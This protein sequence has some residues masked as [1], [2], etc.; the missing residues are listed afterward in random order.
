MWM[1]TS[2]FY[3]IYTLRFC[4]AGEENTFDPSTWNNAAQPETN[5]LA[6]I[7][8]WIPQIR[9]TGADTVYFTP[10]F[11]SDRHGYD[12][13]DYYTIDSRLGSDEDFAEV[14]RVLHAAGLRVVLDAVFNHVGRGFWAFRDVQIHGRQSKYVDWFVIDWDGDSDFADGF[15]Y[16]GWEGHFDLVKLNLL[17]PEVRRHLFGALEKWV[18]LFH[19]D[20]LRLDVAYCLD[21]SF[22]AELRSRCD[23]LPD[24]RGSNGI[25]L[26][27]ETI[28]GEHY[29]LV[30]DSMLHACTNYELYKSLYSGCN[31]RNMFELSWTLNRQ[32]ELYTP[33]R[34]MTFCD[35]HDVT[36]ITSV[37]ETPQHLLIVYGLLF[38]L[39]GFPC[40]YYG[41]EWGIPGLKE[42]GDN[43]LRPCPPEPHWTEISEK[44]CQLSLI[45][46]NSPAF[47]HGSFREL[48]VRNGQ[49]LFERIHRDH[50]SGKTERIVV[51]VNLE[52]HHE[53]IPE[54]HDGYGKFEGLHGEFTDLLTGAIV[55]F[56]GEL[57]LP[58]FSVQFFQ[59]AR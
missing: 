45:R 24:S 7:V 6:K 28:Y 11:Q 44:I 39:P 13:R 53:G 41:S 47:L 9:R 55:Q 49:Y 48:C 35:N 16:E 51:A 18:S 32:Q 27:G 14:C 54:A 59:S 12:T 21:R 33:E 17:N 3:Q 38:S 42:N 30:N 15:F 58:P 34:M 37:L 4:G 10:L 26:V 19:V 57:T 52:E 56:D 36:R 25:G 40:L 5:R 29:P 1:Y 23:S 43:D 50:G 22:L 46:K 2:Q 31:D 8:S 20:G